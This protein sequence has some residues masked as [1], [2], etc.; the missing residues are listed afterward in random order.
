LLAAAYA[1]GLAKN[2]PFVDGNKR[3]AFATAVMFLELNGYRFEAGE[4]EAVIRN[5]ALAAGE[6]KENEHAQWLKANSKRRWPPIALATFSE[7]P[8]QNWPRTAAQKESRPRFTEVGCG[9]AS[10]HLLAGSGVGLRGSIVATLLLLPT[11]ARHAA[12][13]AGFACFLARPFVR[14]PLLMRRLATLARN[15]ALLAAVHRRKSAIFFC[16]RTLPARFTPT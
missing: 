16:H 6:L 13:A 4:A 3:I 11:V 12:L 15:L 2:R 1:F 7:R 10:H 14:G 8:G 5:L 9:S